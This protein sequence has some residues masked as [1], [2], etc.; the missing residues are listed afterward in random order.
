MKRSES[1]ASAFRNSPDPNPSSNTCASFI[2]HERTNWGNV[3][4]RTSSSTEPETC[5]N[6]CQ[7]NAEAALVARGVSFIVSLFFIFF[8]FDTDLAL[9]FA[10]TF[11]FYTGAILH[12]FQLWYLNHKLPLTV[13]SLYW[14]QTLLYSWKFFFCF[15]FPR[16]RFKLTSVL[17]ANGTKIAY[18]PVSHQTEGTA[19]TWPKQAK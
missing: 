14:S 13:I 12:S 17:A 9:P 15:F 7:E 3:F 4:G 5:G 2:H 18:S 10:R 8:L 1:H 16:K 11:D 19:D 6:S